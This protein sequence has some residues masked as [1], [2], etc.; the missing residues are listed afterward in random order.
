M[1]VK[2]RFY[3]TSQISLKTSKMKSLFCKTVSPQA[4]NYTKKGTITGV[5]L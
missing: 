2:M 1:P 3:K 5:S 4:C